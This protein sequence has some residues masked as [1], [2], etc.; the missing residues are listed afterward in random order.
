M[1]EEIEEQMIVEAPVGE[2]PKKGFLTNWFFGGGDQA[3][4]P[5]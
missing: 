4:V 2:A 5:V 3:S 1:G